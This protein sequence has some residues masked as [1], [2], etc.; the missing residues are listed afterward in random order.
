[1]DT[2]VLLHTC[3]HPLNPAPL[4]PRKA[5]HLQFSEAQPVA[6]DDLCRNSRPENAR[7]FANTEFYRLCGVH[8]GEAR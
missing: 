3:P 7:G 6:D 4:Y 5:V 8:G 1:M 2:L